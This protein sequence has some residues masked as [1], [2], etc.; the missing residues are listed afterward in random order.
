MFGRPGKVLR[1]GRFNAK[2]WIWS[3]HWYTP[4]LRIAPSELHCLVVHA[5]RGQE[6]SGVSRSDPVYAYLSNPSASG[7]YIHLVTT[8]EMRHPNAR[9]N[10]ENCLRITWKAAMHS[11]QELVFDALRLRLEC[12][13]RITDVGKSTIRGPVAMFSRFASKPCS[14]IAAA[15]TDH[16]ESVWFMFFSRRRRITCTSTSIPSSSTPPS[17][18]KASCEM[19]SELDARLSRRD[20]GVMER[21]FHKL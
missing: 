4:F 16:I 7:G 8:S 9:A 5:R 6:G 3:A 10:A 14:L 19:L 17:S 11:F 21:A 1:A 12:F 20:Y 18:R 13:E 15:A 2:I